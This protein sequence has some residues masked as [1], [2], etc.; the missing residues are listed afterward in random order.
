MVTWTVPSLDEAKGFLV[1]IVDFEPATGGRR[2]RQ[3]TAGVLCPLSLS[4]CRVPVE[5]GGVTVSGLD[6]NVVYSVM[7]VAENGDSVR[8][9]MLTATCT[10]NTVCVCVWLLQMECVVSL[11]S[12]SPETTPSPDPAPAIP[13]LPVIVGVVVG[14][15]VLAIVVVILIIVVLCW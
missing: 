1:Y 4:P 10:C 2:K 9:E 7:V 5:D 15:L 14:A 11:Y 13:L 3:Q 6:P 12:A 8:G